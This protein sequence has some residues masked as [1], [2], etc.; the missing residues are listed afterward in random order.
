M[1]DALVEVPTIRC[2]A[3]IELISNKIPYRIMSL[4]LRHLLEKHDL[5]QQNL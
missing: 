3:G 4:G 5:G 1:D 2:F